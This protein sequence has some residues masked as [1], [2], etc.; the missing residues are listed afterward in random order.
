MAPEVALGHGCGFHSDVY[1]FGMVL[2]EL[3]TLEKPFLKIKNSDEFKI[4]VAAQGLRP[5]CTEIQRGPLK[6]LIKECWDS[7][8]L[9]RPRFSDIVPL[10]QSEIESLQQVPADPVKTIRNSKPWHRQARIL[11]A[12][13]TRQWKD[14][15]QLMRQS[16]TRA[17]MG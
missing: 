11:K 1:S 17:S 12:Q 13:V 5:L 3:V 9:I 2:W 4:K 15:R 14:Y 8:P 7:Q 6:A 16:S 10:L